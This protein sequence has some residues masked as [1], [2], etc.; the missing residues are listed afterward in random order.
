[1]IYREEVTCPNLPNIRQTDS[2][3]V[4]TN[5]EEVLVLEVL[6]QRRPARTGHSNN[7]P[8]AVGLLTHGV[9]WVLGLAG[10]LHVIMVTLRYCDLHYM[11]M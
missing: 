5:C 3:R 11:Y 6:W 4:S 1:M 10:G 8:C 2:T 7:L 9:G